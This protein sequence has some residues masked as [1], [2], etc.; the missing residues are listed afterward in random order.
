MHIGRAASCLTIVFEEELSCFMYNYMFAS[1]DGRKTRRNG[2][3]VVVAMFVLVFRKMGR[4]DACR[5]T[6]AEGRG[7]CVCV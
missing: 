5:T 1:T 7:V 3:T 2:S 4:G 6:A